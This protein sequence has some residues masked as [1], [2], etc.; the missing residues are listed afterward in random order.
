MEGEL[1]TFLRA[2]LATTIVASLALPM[3]FKL[4]RHANVVDRPNF[5][6]LHMTD[7]PR[8]A[9]LALCLGVVA[10]FVVTRTEFWPLFFV[11]IGFS[12]LG[13]WDDFASRSATVRLALQIV[14]ALIG[15]SAVVE[16]EDGNLLY[17][18]IGTALIVS[19]VNATNFMDGINGMS[20]FTAM[21]WGVCYG[22]MLA[23]AGN[24]VAIPL[25]AALA[26]IG[27]VF[28][29]WN[30]PKA[31]LFL[32]DAGSYLI[33]SIAAMLV[34]VLVLEGEWIAALCPLAT[35]AADTGSTFIHRLARGL[36]PYT[37]H[38]DHVFQRLV[39]SGWSH[40]ATTLLTASFSAAS[41]AL[42]LIAFGRSL[43]TQ[44]LILAAVL[45]INSLF[46]L[47]PRITVGRGLRR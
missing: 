4:L 45:G 32:G 47:L 14:I 11:P 33:G 46:I 28:L 1:S 24:A 22:L 3:A 21:I 5:R 23:K 16:R 2:A 18:L 13:A 41:A 44:L 9:G 40:T 42:G 6:S 19:V 35:Y 17:L 25:A 39:K 29:P 34:L 26:A 43:G 31:R 38:T 12:L 20:G 27:L 8:G 37:P 7:T 30:F 36:N 15:V 10:A